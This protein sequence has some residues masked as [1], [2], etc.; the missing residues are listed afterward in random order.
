LNT[1][2]E[3]SLHHRIH[4]SSGADPASLSNGYQGLFSWKW[5][6]WDVKLTIHL[7]LVPRSNNA[8]NS[9]FTTASRCGA[10]LRK[11]PGTTLHFPYI[12]WSSWLCKSILR[13]LYLP[14]T[15]IHTLRGCLQKFPDWPLGARTAN[16]TALCH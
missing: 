2:E 5:G 13:L 3:L 1:Y 4:T 7:H 15:H 16:G 10:K 12:L 6:G 14:H 8:W 9:N 11:F